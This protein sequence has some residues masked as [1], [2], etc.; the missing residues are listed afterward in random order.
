MIGNLVDQTPRLRFVKGCIVLQKIAVSCV[1]ACFLI[2][3]LRLQGN[4]RNSPGVLILFAMITLLS[5]FLGLN[6]VRS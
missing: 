2:L 5:S 4:A 1:Y 3:F 6:T